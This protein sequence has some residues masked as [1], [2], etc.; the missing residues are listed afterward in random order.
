[1]DTLDHSGLARRSGALA[2][3]L[4]L[5]TRGGASDSEAADQD[6]RGP[7]TT[8]E[9]P[10]L[11]R[12]ISFGTRGQF[13][14]GGRDVECTA[15]PR[16]SKRASSARHRSIKPGTRSSFAA[17]RPAHHWSTDKPLPDSRA[18]CAC[19]QRRRAT[20]S[21]AGQQRPH[22]VA[23]TGGGRVRNRQTHRPRGYRCRAGAEG[24]GRSFRDWSTRASRPV[25]AFGLVV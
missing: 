2:A 16:P 4:E 6:G 11:D 3:P 10:G 21:P 15:P 1:M 22:A 12:A 20:T 23:Q 8:T 14:Q 13:R 7:G 5:V 19:T 17:P 9:R 24:R 25:F 18:P